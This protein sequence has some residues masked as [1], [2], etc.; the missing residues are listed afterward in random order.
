M[1]AALSRIAVRRAVEACQCYLFPVP[2]PPD[3]PAF[4]WFDNAAGYRAFVDPGTA[5]RRASERRMCSRKYQRGFC[6]YCRRGVAFQ[7]NMGL[8]MDE[9]PNLREGMVCCL[10]GLGN[11]L[12]LIYKGIEDHCCGPAGLACRR[13]YV[14]ERITR[15]FARL[16]RRIPDLAGSEYLSPALASGEIRYHR[17]SRKTIMH[18]DLQRTSFPDN[19]FDIVVHGDVLE[20]VVHY[21]EVLCEILRIL[22]PGGCTI[23]SVPFYHRQHHHNIHAVIK[24]NGEISHYS[25]PEIHGNPIDDAGSLVFQTFGWRLLEDLRA[26]GFAKAQIGVL[27]D[28]RQ[29]FTSNN[30]SETYYMEPVIFKAEKA[31]A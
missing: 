19:Y 7:V 3:L 13:I 28:Y 24:E 9:G 30:A 6:A 16:A 8:Y 29:G 27:P 21:R 18:Q 14:A 5:Q 26:A 1:K 11:R 23:F 20:H 10:C 25:P 22:A 31:A 4:H 17:R 12:R 15:F 2:Y